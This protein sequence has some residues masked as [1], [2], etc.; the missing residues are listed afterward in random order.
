MLPMFVLPFTRTMHSFNSMQLHGKSCAE[1]KN[2][3]ACSLL[4]LGRRGG[5]GGEGRWGPDAWPQRREGDEH[6]EQP[7]LVPLTHFSV[8]KGVI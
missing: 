6:M 5:G 8:L 2:S 1:S 4:L 7:L 3:G